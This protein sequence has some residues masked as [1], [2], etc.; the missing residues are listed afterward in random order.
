MTLTIVIAATLYGVV[1]G[2]VIRVTT[3]TPTTK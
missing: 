1:M 3:P 2:Y